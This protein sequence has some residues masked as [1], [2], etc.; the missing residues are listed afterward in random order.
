MREG[1]LTCNRHC[2]SAGITPAR[3]GRTGLWLVDIQIVQDH[4][5]VCGKDLNADS[6]ELFR[7][8]SPRVCGKASSIN[9]INC[10]S[11]GSPPRMREGLVVDLKLSVRLRITPA[12]AGRTYLI[13]H[14]LKDL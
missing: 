10:L 3:A 11:A 5:R 6:K 2:S 14:G 4:P 1:Q 7:I 12:R 13:S 8:G 9:F